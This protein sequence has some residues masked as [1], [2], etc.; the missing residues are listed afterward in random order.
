MDEQKIDKK[1]KSRR[2]GQVLE[3]GA[4]KWLIR[5]FRGYKPNGAN[6]YFNKTLHGTKKEAE[7]WLRGALARKD[8]GEPLEDP[9]ITFAAL[10]EEWL[11]SKKRKS[12][13]ADF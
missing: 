9:N 5:I 2:V 3:R 13:T 1:A 12:R 11:T 8:R 10:F 6:D 4:N 7:K